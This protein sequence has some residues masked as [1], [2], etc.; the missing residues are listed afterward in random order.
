MKQLQSEGELSIASTGKDPSTGRLVTH[1]YRVKGPTALFM[2]TTAIDLDEE[3]M[4]RCVVLTVDEDREQTRAIHRMQREAETLEGYFAELDRKELLELHRNA[5]RL[6]KPLRVVNPFA[7]RLT[8]LDVKTR[9]R[10]DHLKYLALIRAIA[11]LHQHQRPVL[12]SEH[13]GRQRAYIEATL[14]D[15]EVANRLAHEVLGRTLDELPPQTRRFLLLLDQLAR[16]ACEEQHIPR[17]E[18][19]LTRAE[20]RRHTG[21]SLTQVKVHLDRLAEMEYVLIHRGGR[22]QSFVYE[23]LWAGEGKEGETFL[24]GL[25]DVE[26]LRR[27]QPSQTRPTSA[28]D[29]NLS[30]SGGG[31]SESGEGVTES[32]AHLSGSKRGQN[33]PISGG[34]RTRRK[35]REPSNGK[36]FPAAAL[37]FPQE[38]TTRG[39]SAEPASSYVG[40]RRSGLGQAGG[41]PAGE[42]EKQQLGRKEDQEGRNDQVQV[43]QVETDQVES[44]R[45]LSRAAGSGAGGR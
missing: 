40:D 18:L 24:M 30:A 36:G 5:Q 31:V 29:P 1:E 10:R 17:V 37:P 41:L 34:C 11:L 9:T 16:Q 45:R 35:P 42:H 38:G 15:I 4:N 44:G 19:R 2:T 23:L 20:I 22:G 6:L 7:R 27:E 14:S 8:F 3:L 12:E 33:G 39:A 21:W 32:E 43:D 13:R 25:L 28:P 26:A